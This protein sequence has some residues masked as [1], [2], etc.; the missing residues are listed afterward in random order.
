MMHHANVDRLLA[1]WQA[2]NYQKPLSFAGTTSGQ[3]GTPRGPTSQDDPLK[4][5]NNVDK[6]YHTSASVASIQSF[7]YSYPEI[8]FWRYSPA[9][10][11]TACKHTIN[12]L[13]GAGTKTL[14]KRDGPPQQQA[15]YFVQLT[16][17]RD[18]L[19][20]PCKVIVLL[21]GREA[22]RIGL[23]SVPAVGV[24]HDEIPLG[25]PQAVPTGTGTDRLGRRTA[26]T[27]EALRSFFGDVLQVRVLRVRYIPSH[28]H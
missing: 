3:M 8:P 15:K 24:S 10:L 12:T 9:D 23:L 17:K 13:Y 6:T 21:H 16:M 4:P 14:Q 26:P 28:L 11:S 5:F 25:S 1:I 7:A 27:T 18:K 2:I 22:G 20:L 19:P